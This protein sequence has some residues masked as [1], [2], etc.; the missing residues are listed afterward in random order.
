MRAG[1]DQPVW[2]LRPPGVGPSMPVQPQRDGHRRRPQDRGRRQPHD[3]VP[4]ELEEGVPE[5]G[6]SPPSEGEE[7]RVDVVV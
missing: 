5:G 7:Q 4:T 3:E 6:S 1:I 2:G